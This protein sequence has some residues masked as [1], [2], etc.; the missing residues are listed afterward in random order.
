VSY[1]DRT[2]VVKA[3]KEIYTAPTLEAAELGLAVFDKQFG[4]H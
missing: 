3:M 2:K 4:T 1:G